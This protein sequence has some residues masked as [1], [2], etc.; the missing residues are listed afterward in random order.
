MICSC[1]RRVNAALSLSLSLSLFLSLSLSSTILRHTLTY[2][3]RH[4]DREKWVCPIHNCHYTMLVQLPKQSDLS[5]KQK[6][7]VPADL[8]LKKKFFVPATGRYPG[9][10]SS[11][12]PGVHHSEEGGREERTVGCEGGCQF[13][14]CRFLQTCPP[15]GIQ[16][17]IMVVFFICL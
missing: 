11:V 16:G 10:W 13:S 3:H 7:F 17:E 8:S 14:C 9:V 15:H 4:N 1:P 2:T 12:Q 6:F 5:L